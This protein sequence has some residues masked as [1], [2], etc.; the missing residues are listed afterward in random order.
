MCACLLRMLVGGGRWGGRKS[1]GS[2]QITGLSRPPRQ[3][4]GRR[5]PASEGR[6]AERLLLAPLQLLALQPVG[7]LPRGGP[8]PSPMMSADSLAQSSPLFLN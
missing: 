3:A 6:W 2:A 1:L 7:R 5:N 8:S 4:L